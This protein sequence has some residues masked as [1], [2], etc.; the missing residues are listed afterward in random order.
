MTLVLVVGEQLI[1]VRVVGLELLKKIRKWIQTGDLEKENVLSCG[2]A[3]KIKIDA[4]V[5]KIGGPENLLTLSGLNDAT[6]HIARQDSDHVGLDSLRRRVDRNV[7]EDGRCRFPEPK[8][9]FDFGCF[10][11]TSVKRT[12][13]FRP[14]TESILS[15][16]SLF[17]GTVGLT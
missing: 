4:W 9:I 3:V 10:R 8:F 14:R 6:D 7:V 13:P 11:S 2:S 1:D 17:C 16:S 5:K 15:P 12:A